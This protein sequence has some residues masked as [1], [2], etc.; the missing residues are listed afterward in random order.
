MIAQSFRSNQFGSLTKKGI[1]ART[2]FKARGAKE[3]K[4][5]LYAKRILEQV[6]AN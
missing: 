1:M 3:H 4:S 2:A 6:I 5:R